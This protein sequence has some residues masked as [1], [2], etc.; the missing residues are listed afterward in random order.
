MNRRTER[1]AA[2]WKQEREEGRMGDEW[3]DGRKQGRMG[4]WKTLL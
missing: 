1:L 3:T 4:R 2:G